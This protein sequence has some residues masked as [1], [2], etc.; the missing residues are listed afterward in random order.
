LKKLF[1][2]RH[3]SMSFSES[4]PVELSLTATAKASGRRREDICLI[5][6]SKTFSSE[7]ISPF[8]AQ[9]HRHFG[10]NRLQEALQKWPAL[11]EIYPDVTL[12]LLGSLQSNKARKALALFDCIHSLDR[13]S[14]ARQLALLM[15][16]T[17]KKTDCFIQVN[18]A[19]EEQKSGISIDEADSFIT[20]CRDELALPIIGLM[21]IP[22]AEQDPT[23]YFGLLRVIAERNSLPYLS[24]GM[25]GDF[26]KAVA[27]GATHVRLGSALFGARG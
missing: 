18:I 8:L 5:A 17:G 2:E 22:P 20:L 10:E 12:H 25:S 21:A 16:E 23:P 27:M 13:P 4:H 6:V 11:K 19:A 15:Q 9:G 14:L 7:L 24:M 1:L 3:F 26:E